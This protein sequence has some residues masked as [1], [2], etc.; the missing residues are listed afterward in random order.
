M[1]NDNASLVSATPIFHVFDISQA[2]DWYQQVLG[3]QIAWTW[4]EPISN[5]SVC[6][7]AAE[8]NL[9]VESGSQLSIARAYFETHNVDAFHDRVVQA[10]GNVTIPLAD[11]PYGMRDFRVIDPTGNE[12]S[13]GEPMP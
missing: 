1:T 2:L 6:R 4:G 10:G 11:R 13:F 5:A 7:D 12:L 8:I 3:F 9:A